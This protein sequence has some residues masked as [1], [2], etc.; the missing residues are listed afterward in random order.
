MQRIE[1]SYKTIVFTVFFLLLLW[2]LYLIK[3]IIVLFFISFILMSALR[4]SVEKLEK[5]KIPRSLAIGFIY[6]LIILILYFV[7]RVIFPPMI[8]ETI[9]LV[10]SIAPPGS[11]P[12]F[13][14]EI[15]S[16]IKNLN[17]E[18][19]S[20]ITPY[21][22]NVVDVLKVTVSIF[23]GIISALTLFM[24]T[25]YLLLERKNLGAL[26]ES[27][28]PEEQAK[29]GVLIIESVEE[30]LGAWTRGQ[31]LLCIIIGI[32]TFIGLTILKVS[33]ALPLSIIAALFEIVPNIGP[34][35]SAIPAV[36]VTLAISPGLALATVI[37]FIVIHQVENILVVPNV[38][39]RVV[40]LSPVVTIAALMVGGELMGIGGALL[41]IPVVLVLQTV[42]QELLKN[43]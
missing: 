4:P 5:L 10:N 33:Y 13:Y 11:L 32:F 42:I 19:F 21:G 1:I 12:S 16:F 23:G 28:L 24:F 30:R 35:I 41:S 3:G 40:G 27:F 17:L 9:H 29:K 39:K 6:V 26:L 22:G 38:M 7:G 2:F 31:F 37:L 20:K 18:G 8:D 25:F 14:Q 34:I 43:R 36:L 15:L